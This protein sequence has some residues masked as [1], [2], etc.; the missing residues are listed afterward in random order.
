VSR[1]A[2]ARS[3]ALLV[4]C[5]AAA[6]APASAHPL[7]PS[8]LEVRAKA[9]GTADVRWKTPLVRPRGSSLSPVWPAG[10]ERV[11]D[12]TLEIE[13]TG[14]V[15][16]F[17]LRCPF[18]DWTGRRL[19][20]EGLDASGTSALVRLILP[21]GLEHSVLLT[22]NAPSWV[23]PERPSSAAVAW[24]YTLLGAQHL[25]LGFDHVLFLMG[26]LL[27][28]D[29]RRRLVATITAFTL[30]HSLTLVLATLDVVRIPTAPVEVAIAASILAPAVEVVR[31]KPGASRAAWRSPW[32]MALAFGLLHGLGFAGALAE[33]GLPPA[34]IP[35][36]LFSFNVGIE[37]GQLAWAAIFGLGVVVL[38]ATAGHGLSPAA[39][40]A[41]GYALGIAAGA[42]FWTRV[43]AWMFASR[44]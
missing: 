2:V 34:S 31:G 16:R 8:L 24:R 39:R 32:A 25:V 27:L 12:P 11:G 28:V 37:L 43:F 6:A 17:E 7:A 1:R 18:S 13:G 40:K 14:R 5:A 19:H 41:L 15:E 36:A 4:A 9:D 44:A 20:V 29:S 35:L 3:V 22:A 26:L 10:C 23:V 30:G 21:D 42:W 38:R 33:L